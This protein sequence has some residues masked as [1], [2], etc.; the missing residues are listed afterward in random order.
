MLYIFRSC[1]IRMAHF[2]MYTAESLTIVFKGMMDIFIEN[3]ID[4]LL[5]C[6]VHDRACDFHPFVSKL[7][8]AG[9][10]KKIVNLKY[11]VDIFHAEKHTMAKCV[12]GNS[13][14]KYHPDQ[15][16]FSKED[17]HGSM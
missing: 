3:E 2:E 10:A 15:P 5:T 1:D 14:C 11:I 8:N 9:N 4:L 17:E 13:D 7:A 12:L 6:I 16:E